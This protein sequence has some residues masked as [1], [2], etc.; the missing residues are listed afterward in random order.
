MPPPIAWRPRELK[1]WR[2]ERW[3]SQADLAELLGVHRVTVADWE[4][5]R[6]GIPPYLHYALAHLDTL[7]TWGPPVR[8]RER[9]VRRTLQVTYA[10]LDGVPRLENLP[11]RLP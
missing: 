11:G 6:S 2:A 10:K 4:G 3:V 8:G 5:G 7:E 1:S 9:E